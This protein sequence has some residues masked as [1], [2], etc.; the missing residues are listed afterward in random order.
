MRALL[1]WQTSWPRRS[2]SA[3]R[4]PP[5]ASHPLAGQA[6][7]SSPAQQKCLRARACSKHSFAPGRSFVFPCDS[8]ASYGRG[9]PAAAVRGCSG[10][11]RGAQQ[12][13]AHS[14][15]VYV[16]LCGSPWVLPPNQIS[17]DCLFQW[18]S[19][20]VPP[21]RSSVRQSPKLS[22]LIPLMRLYYLRKGN[23]IVH[24]T[25]GQGFIITRSN[26]GAQSARRQLR[27]PHLVQRVERRAQG[28]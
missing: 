19:T 23:L 15:W 22:N 2:L 6:P 28:I 18:V 12:R 21:F 7:V 4:M 13:K 11:A 25:A 16:G 17:A 26:T 5:R 20:W 27:Q 8:K 10:L 1:K 24:D 14:V 9:R 3:G